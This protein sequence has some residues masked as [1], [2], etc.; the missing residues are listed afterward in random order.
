MVHIVTTGRKM[1]LK[2]ASIHCNEIQGKL[3]SIYIIFIDVGLK[4]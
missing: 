4:P 1:Y 2:R 3:A